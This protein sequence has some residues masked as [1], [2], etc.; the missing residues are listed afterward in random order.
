MYKKKILPF[1]IILSFFIYSCGFAPQYAGFKNLEFD[2]VIDQV[3]G[4]RDFNN[5]IK[6]QLK[7]YDRGRDDVEKIKISYDSKYEKIILSK[8]TK[9]EATK[10]NL[11][12]NV[13]FDVNS[14]NYST[15]IIFNDEFSIDKIDD[16]IEE[17]NYI[18]IVKRNFAERAI[19]KIILNIRQNK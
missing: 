14:E 19:E 1:L 18:K 6:F 9:G 12:V 11:K 8:N 3:N 17:N 5:E 2:L 4:D 13:I 7:R 15:K 10:Y 16:T